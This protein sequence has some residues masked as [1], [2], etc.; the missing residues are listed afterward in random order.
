MLH[1]RLICAS[2]RYALTLPLCLLATDLV[3]AAELTGQVVSVLDSDTLDVLRNGQAERIRLNGVDCPE[4]GQPYGKRAKRFLSDLVGG[5]TV[6]I[7]SFGHDRHR[8]TIANVLLADGTNVN[9]E[10]VKAGLAWWY[11]KYSKDESLGALEAEA[12]E[13]KRGLWAEP[14]PIPPWVYR[15]PELAKEESLEA[16]T[17][18]KGLAALPPPGPQAEGPIIGNR[19]S[20]KY[21]RPDCPSYTATTPKNRIIFKTE[22]EAKKAGYRMAGNCP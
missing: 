5:K 11:R 13:A 18:A 17:L 19:N 2:L 9:R 6:G 22:E 8:R 4:K 14:N 21:H 16:D 12:R 1:H 15:H 3:G 7:Q 20:R 10:L